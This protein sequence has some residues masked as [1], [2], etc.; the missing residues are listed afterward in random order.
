M[1][2]P[3]P[4][5]ISNLCSAEQEFLK[6]SPAYFQPLPLRT[7]EYQGDGALKPNLS[8]FSLFS[9]AATHTC[10]HTFANCAGTL[11]HTNS[12]AEQQLTTKLYE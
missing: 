4:L 6:Q 1:K 9:T 5:D 2:F 12:G 8:C 10:M 3:S 11:V 7:A